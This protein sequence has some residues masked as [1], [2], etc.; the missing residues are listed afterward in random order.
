MEAALKQAELEEEAECLCQKEEADW[1]RREEATRKQAE[2]EAAAA[3]G[4]RSERHAKAKGKGKAVESGK[5]AGGAKKSKEVVESDESK[6]PALPVKRK[7]SNIG[8]SEPAVVEA[9]VPCIQ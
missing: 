7:H 1:L 5:S 3:E 4:R 2:V 6:G 8:K 9:V